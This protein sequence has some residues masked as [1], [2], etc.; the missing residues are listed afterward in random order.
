MPA[1]RWWKVV[2]LFL[3]AEWIFVL[4]LLKEVRVDL[5]TDTSE[6]SFIREWAD[7]FPPSL[8]LIVR[9]DRAFINQDL[10]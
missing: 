6:F 2:M 8:E 10:P 4:Q 3:V 9:S 5:W 7:A 1:L